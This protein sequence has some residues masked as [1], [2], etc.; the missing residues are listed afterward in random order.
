MQNAASG[1]KCAPSREKTAPLVMAGPDLEVVC[2]ACQ[3]GAKPTA[4]IAPDDA[5]AQGLAFYSSQMHV[6]SARLD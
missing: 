6:T 3:R 1:S 5:C 2:G 4:L